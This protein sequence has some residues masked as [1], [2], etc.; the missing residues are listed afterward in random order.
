VTNESFS[1][2]QIGLMSLAPRN[3]IVW[4]I[5]C[6]SGGI[7]AEDCFGESWMHRY[8]LGAVAF[9]GSTVNAKAY[10]S[11]DLNQ[12]LF[13]AVYSQDIRVQGFTYYDAEYRMEN[14]K[15]SGDSWKYL[16]LGDPEMTI[17]TTQPASPWTVGAPWVEHVACGPGGCPEIR[18]YVTLAG[19]G[20]AVGVRVGVY[21]PPTP[22]G[23]GVADNRY[24]DATGLAAIPAPGLGDGLMYYT[25]VDDEGNCDPDTV[26]LQGGQ[27]VGVG[28]PHAWG[29]M[30]L[31]AV[32]SVV[33]S[34]TVFT[35]GRPALG[36]ARLDL[37]DATGRRVRSLAVASSAVNVRWDADDSSGGRVASGI[38][39][40]RFR[41]SRGQANARLVV[42][43]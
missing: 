13:Y 7:Q 39:L 16:L 2:A 26:S 34:G 31:R 10:P 37:Y 8:G 36:P 40:A 23:A 22:G 15:K 20:P 28:M 24:T 17:R 30:S 3:P 4:S 32:P 38:Y 43:R 27:V 35:L 12:N 1:S 6:Q 19:G 41:D 33:H 29:S 21:Q 9:Y 11:I 5:A 18:M 25:V 14:L 42:L